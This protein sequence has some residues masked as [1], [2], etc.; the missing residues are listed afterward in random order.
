MKSKTIRYTKH[1][2][3]TIATTHTL[4]GTHAS[5]ILIREADVYNIFIKDNYQDSRPAALDHAHYINANVALRGIA[6]DSSWKQG[7]AM[8]KLQLRESGFAI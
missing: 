1:E 2:L 4:E 7:E 3:D 8:T 5:A 6:L